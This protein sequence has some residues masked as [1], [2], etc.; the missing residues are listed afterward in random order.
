M[1]SVWSQNSKDFFEQSPFL[2]ERYGVEDAISR[3]DEG[4][5]QQP[6]KFAAWL[7][8][9]G[10]ETASRMI[11][12][13][14]Y[15]QAQRTGQT[16]PVQY[17]D[18]ITRR[19]VAGRGIGELPISQQSKALQLFTPFQVEV[20]NTW[21][22][23]KE[24]SK[25]G[26]KGARGLLLMFIASYLANGIAESLTGR[27]IS[28]DPIDAIKSAIEGRDDDESWVETVKNAAT[29]LT[30]EIASS[31]PMISALAPLT[32]GDEASPL[33]GENDPTRF[34]T[35]NIGITAFLQPVID[36]IQGKK[37]DMAEFALNFV[38]PWGGRQIQ[39]GLEA[40][41]NLGWIPGQA[42]ET[43]IP[44]SY[45]DDGKLRF[46]VDSENISDVAKMFLF[47]QWATD[48]GQTYLEQ[49]RKPMSDNRLKGWQTSAKWIPIEEY[50][51]I[52]GSVKMTDKKEVV[53]QN[54]MDLGYSRVD[55]ERAYDMAHYRDK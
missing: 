2:K 9:F 7:M 42:Q 45:T 15:E 40:A 30:G 50:A 29:N 53:I 48:E 27:R 16:N 44:G 28:I 36:A 13:S 23:M 55:A 22:L 1:Q 26:F 35:G 38:T 8:G 41:E 4:I 12:A 39:R 31:I 34:G 33:F 37:P 5:L 20:N 54:I 46:P 18:D 10:D 17:A 51:Q 47:G 24:Q 11:W 32:L 43:G 21:Q 3:F 6:K 14:A 25:N 52:L 19:S 49:G